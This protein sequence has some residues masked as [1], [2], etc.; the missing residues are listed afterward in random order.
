VYLVYGRGDLDP[1]LNGNWKMG[2]GWVGP[3]P[4]E[5]GTW[6]KDGGPANHFPRF[7]V[8][9]V[10]RRGLQI[11]VGFGQHPGW[12]YRNVNLSR[13]GRITGI[14]EIGPIFSCDR[15]I[16]DVL[17]RELQLDRP[18][19]LEAFKLRQPFLPSPERADAA[20]IKKLEET[21]KIDPPDPKFQYYVDYAVFYGNGPE[22]IDHLSDDFDIP[23]FLA[24]QK[25]YIEGN[26]WCETHSNPGYLTAT[27]YGVN[28]SWAMCPILAAGESGIDLRRRKPP[29]EIE[30]GVITPDDV[31]PWNLWWTLGLYDEK[32]KNYPWTPGLKNVP[33]EGVKFFNKWVL[34]PVKV[35]DNPVINLE[36]DPPLPQSILAHKPLYMLIQVADEHRVRVGFKAN[37]ADPWTF[38]KAFD[39]SKVFGK[40]TRLSYPCLVSFQGRGVVGKG[41][42]AGNYPGYQKFKFDYWYYRYGLS[43]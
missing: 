40:I 4:A 25:Y 18:T 29:F 13:F 39:S 1:S 19:W 42:G 9:L 23:G 7:R 37:K 8:S 11:G 38:S 21:F 6:S 28:S 34:D 16:P 15:W 10:N 20:S 26:G 17:A 22:N 33:G 30:I 32:G 43:K 41:W 36:F 31:M 14:W 5:S 27:L 2:Y 12:R 3:D 35:E 24:D